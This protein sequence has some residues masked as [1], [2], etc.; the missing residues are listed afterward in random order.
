MSSNR[1]R[2]FRQDVQKY[3]DLLH[4]STGPLLD[5]EKNHDQLRAMKTSLI[6]Q[7]AQLE[8]V[9]AEYS[10]KPKYFDPVWRVALDAYELALSS[11][12]LQRRGPALDAI[13]DDLDYI[14]AKLESNPKRKINRQQQS[15]RK[16]PPK[17][18]SENE[19][20]IN[21]GVK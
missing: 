20:N 19:F 8:D 1:V 2:K 17:T 9:I 15:I 3:K 6:K 10:K 12:I 7:Y 18:K 11:D 14:L 5:I 21:E 16:A 13:L 4:R